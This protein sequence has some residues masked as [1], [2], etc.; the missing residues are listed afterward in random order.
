MLDLNDPQ[1]IEL[2]TKGIPLTE[3]EARLR[4]CFKEDDYYKELA[5]HGGFGDYSGE[6][7][8]GYKEDLLQLVH[9]DWEL[10][11]EYNLNHRVIADKIER[12][13]SRGSTKESI[14]RLFGMGLL[15]KGYTYSEPSFQT[16]GTQ[17]CPWE[18]EIRGQNVGMIFDKTLSDEERVKAEF[19][20]ENTS[21]G[22]YVLL[23]ELSPHLIRE[24]YFFEGR[25]SPFRMDPLFLIKA[26]GLG[27]K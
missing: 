9:K 27:K 10:L 4:P 13:I 2:V 23:T 21:S 26:F 24:H 14:F 20:E 3:L 25:D 8:I 12:L 18:C 16:M 17:P 11:E 15:K 5:L 7:F 19:G 1:F 22:R 6:G